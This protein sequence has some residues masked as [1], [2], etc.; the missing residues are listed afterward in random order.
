MS[1][2]KI[3]VV[4]DDK[5]LVASIRVVL[6]SAGYEVSAAHDPQAGLH[7]AETER[8]DLILLDVMMPHGTE[9]FHFVWK[10]RQH[11]D[12]KIR[13]LPII[14]LS[15]IHDKTELR[16]YPDSSD[17]TYAPGEFLPVEDFVDKPV[18]PEQL[19]ECIA[20]VLASSR[21]FGLA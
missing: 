18:D 2:G 5:D 9:G 14:I 12:D 19:L 1:K 13:R 20:R 16:F 15:A 4:E 21:T 6:E 17:G 8:P 7:L 11:E 3:L 10:L